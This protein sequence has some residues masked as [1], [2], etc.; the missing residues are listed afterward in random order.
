MNEQI[1]MGLVEP[2]DIFLSIK[3][4]FAG[5]I[6]SREKTHEFRRYKPKD[7]IKRIWFYVTS[8]DSE[9]KYIAE[10]GKVVEYPNQIPEDG[11]GNVDFNQ[12]LKFSKFAFPIL[13]LNE[14]VE[15]ISLNRLK[16]QF[17]F[18]PPQKYIYTDSFPELVGYAT[19]CGIRRIY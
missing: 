18:N 15:G 5:L 13:H 2:R 7:Q 6:N 4:K 10:V 3:S 19:S 14:L 1:I 16:S 12:G 8:P 11:I 17:N 9:L